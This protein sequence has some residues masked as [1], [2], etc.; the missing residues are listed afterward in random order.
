LGTATTLFLHIGLLSLCSEPKEDVS[1]LQIFS[2]DN[3]N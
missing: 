2:L 1:K 3:G